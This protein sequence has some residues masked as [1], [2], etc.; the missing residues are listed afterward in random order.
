MK[1]IKTIPTEVLAEVRKDLDHNKPLLKALKK[2]KPGAND[3]LREVLKKASS[4]HNTSFD[5]SVLDIESL[6]WEILS[7]AH[8]T[9]ANPS[10]GEVSVGFMSDRKSK[11]FQATIQVDGNP[12]L[13][14]P[15]PE[16]SQPSAQQVEKYLAAFDKTSDQKLTE[17][18]KELAAVLEE[19]EKH[20][21]NLRHDPMVW[22]SGLIQ[23]CFKKDKPLLQDSVQRAHKA[24]EE[25]H[26]R[27]RSIEKGVHIVSPNA[28]ALGSLGFKLAKHLPRATSISHLLHWAA[29]G[30]HGAIGVADSINVFLE[31]KHGSKDW[32]DIGLSGARALVS[33]ASVAA[34]FF[35]L[36]TLL[37]SAGITAILLTLTGL[38]MKHHSKLTHDLK[39]RIDS[40]VQKTG[41]VIQKI[42]RNASG[43]PKTKSKKLS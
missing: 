41:N 10:V 29:E 24:L 25:L 28:L 13:T 33:F 30:L 3:E 19:A 16:E 43:D 42:L 40:A 21:G 20:T 15:I 32:K 35:H 37:V 34:A 23:R 9:V 38:K 26:G 31:I 1:D 8:T 39:E 12:L 5:A 27:H 4:H 18:L 6:R 11:E 14:I 22:L 7:P 2:G 17:S 36:P